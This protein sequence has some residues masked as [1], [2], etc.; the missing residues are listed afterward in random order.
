MIARASVYWR[1]TVYSLGNNLGAGRL[2]RSARA[3]EQIRMAEGRML[4]LVSQDRGDMLLSA[5]VVKGLRSPFSVQCLMH[6]Q[7][8]FQGIRSK[9]HII[10]IIHL[11]F[12]LVKRLRRSEADFS[13]KSRATSPTVGL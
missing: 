6:A 2:S 9:N 8:S 1:L 7:L 12:R 13:A 11:F 10:S 3:A 5:N 4:R